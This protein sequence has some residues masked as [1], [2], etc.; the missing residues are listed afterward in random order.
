MYIINIK[1]NIYTILDETLCS[2]FKKKKKQ[3]VYNRNWAFDTGNSNQK[4]LS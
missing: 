3:L 2:I 4:F 1:Y